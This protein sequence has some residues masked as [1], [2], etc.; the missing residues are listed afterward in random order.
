MLN[1]SSGHLIQHSTFNIQHL[2]FLSTPI[3]RPSSAVD[4]D[5]RAL[6]ARRKEIMKKTLSL[7]LV[8]AFT[9]VLFAADDNPMVGGEA[10]A[11]LK[12]IVSNAVNSP[13]HT[14]LVA[15]V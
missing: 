14:T 11:P 12:D 3:H 15:A 6:D 2:T 4:V 5:D 13:D 9:G 1:D 8:C 7:L 10:M